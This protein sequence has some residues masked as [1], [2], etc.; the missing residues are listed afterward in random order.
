MRN[1]EMWRKTMKFDELGDIE[2]S[3]GGVIEVPEEDSGA[4]RRRDAHG[5]TEEIREI[6]DDDW[7]EWADLFGVTEADFVQ[8]E[9]E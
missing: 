5:N 7:Q 9:D 2:L 1:K 4:I 6:G 3:D 8:E